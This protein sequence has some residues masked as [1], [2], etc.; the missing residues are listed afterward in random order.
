MFSGGGQGTVP[1]SRLFLGGKANRHSRSGCEHP[2]SQPTSAVFA[3]REG[4][5]AKQGES[6]TFGPASTLFQQEA[7]WPPSVPIVTV[8]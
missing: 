4:F 8:A 2:S 5:A 3:I 7:G 1:P 6:L